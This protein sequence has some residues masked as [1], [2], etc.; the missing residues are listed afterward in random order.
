MIFCAFPV[1]EP[2]GSTPSKTANGYVS[3]HGLNILLVSRINEVVTASSQSLAIVGI[4]LAGAC[5]TCSLGEK[6]IESD[7]SEHLSIAG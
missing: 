7:I 4:I 6:Y 5:E 2:S 1:Q 3:Q